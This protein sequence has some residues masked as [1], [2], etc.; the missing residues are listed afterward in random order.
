VTPEQEAQFRTLYEAGTPWLEMGVALEMDCSWLSVLRKRMGIPERKQQ[1]RRIEWTVAMEDDLRV[2]FHLLSHFGLSKRFGVSTDAVKNKL[3]R[4]GLFRAPPVPVDTYTGSPR[5]F[6]D[7]EGIEPLPAF[8]PIAA[9]VLG[10]R[11]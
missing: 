3:H 2:Q 4:M 5:W 6:R 10:M 11:P 1:G 8:H 9:T 7:Q